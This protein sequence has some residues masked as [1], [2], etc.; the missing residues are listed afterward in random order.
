MHLLLAPPPR[1]WWEA[2]ILTMEAIRSVHLAWEMRFCSE[3]KIAPIRFRCGNDLLCLVSIRTS[4][5]DARYM[6][7]TRWPATRWNYL[8]LILP[9]GVRAARGGLA[10]IRNA[11]TPIAIIQHLG[12]AGCAPAA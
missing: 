12:M 3:A 9:S 7:L 11:V 10:N 1:D 5:A 4:R 2:I 6:Q 8:Y